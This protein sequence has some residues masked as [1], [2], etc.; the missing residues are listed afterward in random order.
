MSEALVLGIDAGNTKTDAVLARP[1]GT[2]LAW[3]RSGTGDIYTERGPRAA[4]AEVRAAM[5]GAL[6]GGIR[7]AHIALRL[8]GIDWSEDEELWAE[9]VA[10]EWGFRGGY[11]LKNDGFAGIR[12][13]FPS[14]VGLAITGGTGAAFAARAADGR[15]ASLN[16]WGQH[17][18]GAKGLGIGGYRA[19]VLA[20]LGLGEA[21]ALTE[22]Y[23]EFFDV[24]AVEDLVH[25]FAARRHPPVKATL[26]RAAALVVAAA[27]DDAVAA[28]V[29]EEQAELLAH[30]ALATARRLGD[31]P[32]PVV[33]AGTVLTAAAS[34]L[35]ERVGRVL[36]AS[37]PGVEPAVA[38][39]PAVCGAVLDACAELGAE[40]DER[41]LARL[42]ASLP[43][44]PL[45]GGAAA[46]VTG[47]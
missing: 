34:P 6:A 5:D 32:L 30:Y 4:I 14:G 33:L 8:A 19:V 21:T 40:V 15:E 7:P 20:E 46:A 17:D 37:W 27:A 26:A 43:A 38:R 13:G 23:L 1:D 9:V 10:G 36:A 18:L 45:V 22:R 28:G 35:A 25:L 31:E 11:T 41:T 24:P 29:V 2:V 47:A 3:A 44:A 12:L 39:L 42:T 16:M